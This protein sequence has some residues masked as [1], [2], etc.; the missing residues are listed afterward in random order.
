MKESAGVE[1]KLCTFLTMASDEDECL[2]PLPGLFA[3]KYPLT[4]CETRW[5]PQ[6]VWTC[7][8]SEESLSPALTWNS[9]SMHYTY[10]AIP[11]PEQLLN[12]RNACALT[13]RKY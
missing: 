6:Q 5:T 3:S 2:A 13:E 4:K 9:R 11:A 12:N 7:R 1:V 10:W 8:R